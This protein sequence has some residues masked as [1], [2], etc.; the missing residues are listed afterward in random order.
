MDKDTGE[1]TVR[2]LRLQA[3]LSQAKLAGVLNF[4]Q[5]SISRWETGDSRIS[6]LSR[7]KLA[8]FF[9][10]KPEQISEVRKERSFE[11]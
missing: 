6:D 8:R 10:V 9:G 11:G 3:G 5:A 1:W 4:T 7:Y 2:E